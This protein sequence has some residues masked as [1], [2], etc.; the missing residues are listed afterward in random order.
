[1]TWTEFKQKYTLRDCE[2][3]LRNPENYTDEEWSNAELFIE[4]ARGY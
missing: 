1:M 2:E 3:I 4:R